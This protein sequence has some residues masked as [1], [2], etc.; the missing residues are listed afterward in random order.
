MWLSLPIRHLSR[1]FAAVAM[2]QAL[3]LVAV[4]VYDVIRRFVFNDPTVWAYDL[5]SM[6]SGTLFYLAA[7]Y[8]L[9]E[10]GHVAIDFLSSRFSART[11]GIVQALFYGLLFL[12]ILGWI[13][14]VVAAKAWDTLLSGEVDYTS[15]WA[16]VMWPFYAT[17]A[18]GLAV[19]WLEAF[20]LWLTTLAAALGRPPA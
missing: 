10:R 14:W 3:V 13:S 5:S 11:D 9:R 19:L 18:I 16:P 8:T 12:P 17:I 7:G 2:V 20:V 4:I 6:L 15:L 1:A